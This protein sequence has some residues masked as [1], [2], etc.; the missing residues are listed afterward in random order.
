MFFKTDNLSFYYEKYGSNKQVILILPGWG[1]TRSTFN[2]LIDYLKNYYT[3]YILDYPGF[4]N[5]SI[6]N[7]TLTVYDYADII[8]KFIIS[9]NIKPIVL[10]HSFGGRIIS[11][12]IGK[13][14]LKINKL[15]LIDVAGIKRFSFKIFLKQKLYKSLKFII[16]LLPLK[17]K[18]FYYKKLI[19]YFSSS[20]Y[21]NIPNS[22]KDT[23]KNIINE[24]LRKY[25]KLIDCDTLIIWG[26]KDL[27]TPLKDAYYLRKHINNSGLIIYQN[28]NHFSYLNN[29][30]LTKNI[31]EKF[32]N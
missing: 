28:G 32:I 18:Y 17:K 3:I 16:N 9:E 23:F 30:V 4:G 11:I 7:K 20:D 27:D 2:Y 1:N 26:E 22:M 24:D 13:Y 10:A 25:Y 29:P 14:K 12:L 6:P 5:S 19:N 15:I 8:Y 31:I 21:Q